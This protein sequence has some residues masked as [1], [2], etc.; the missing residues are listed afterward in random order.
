MHRTRIWLLAGFWVVAAALAAGAVGCAPDAPPKV[1]LADSVV[2]PQ[3]CGLVFWVDGLDIDHYQR[4]LAAGKLPNIKHFLV[5]RGVTVRNAVA[6]LPTITYAN[7]VSLSTG[8]LPGHHGVVG[9]KWFDRNELVFQNYALIK[10]YQQVDG[11]FSAETIYEAL[12]DEFTATI[13]TPVRRGATRPIDNWASAGIA[14]HFGYQK[15]INRLTTLRFELIADLARRKG[16]WPKFIVAYFV[17]PDT[18]GHS[19]GASSPQYEEM[20]LDVDAQIGNICRSLNEAGILERTYITLVTDHGVVD[21]PNH[22]DV[23][24][25]FR[26]VRDKPMKKAVPT[27]DRMFGR[28]LSR[29]RRE[30]HFNK[31]RAVVVA[32]GDRRCAIHL[33]VDDDWATR[34]TPE[35]IESFHH[36]YVDPAG[37]GTDIEREFSLHLARWPATDLVMVRLGANSVKVRNGAGGVGVI[38]R[39]VV[40]GRKLYRYRVTEGTDPLGYASNDGMR[41]MMDGRHHSG[42]EWLRASLGTDRPDVVVQLIE[43]NDSPRSGDIVLFARDGWDFNRGNKG[44][45]GGLV[46]REIIVPWLWAGPGLPAGAEI[47]AG[48]TVDLM[49]TML[50]LIGRRDAI[51]SGL[52][53]RSLAEALKQAKVAK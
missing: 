29:R 21:T 11:D 16:K 26:L 27:I 19:H 42:D 32:G 53:G 41:E 52:D 28:G 8:L 7:N 31:A 37:I 47:D 30:A 15:T 36:A 50:D 48:R 45:H 38:D 13:L 22:L 44:G 35:Q 2:V 18:L 33:R 40:D 17:T 5:D 1:R 20:L 43:L 39:V 4:L 23:A 25:R 3:R 51:G 12:S 9:N 6:S 34:P 10:T 46:R 24:G 49:P 14:W